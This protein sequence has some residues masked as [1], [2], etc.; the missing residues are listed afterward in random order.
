MD[1]MPGYTYFNKT[2]K[3]LCV[4]QVVEDGTE[5]TKEQIPYMPHNGGAEAAQLDNDSV[6]SPEKS[7]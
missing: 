2:N 7:I 4:I 6:P 3:V 5:A 1:A